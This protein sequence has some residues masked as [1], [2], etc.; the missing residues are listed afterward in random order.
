LSISILGDTGGKRQT[1]SCRA[2]EEKTIHFDGY[3]KTE[4][5]KISTLKFL[6]IWYNSN[7][8]KLPEK[9]RMISNHQN[10]VLI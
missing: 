9:N 7:Q 3:E 1:T 8:K 10:G 6:E 5:S 2:S 4:N